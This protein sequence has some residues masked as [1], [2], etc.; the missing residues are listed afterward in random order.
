MPVLISN[1][2]EK[3]PVDHDLEHQLTRVVAQAL[4]DHDIPENAE[5]SVVLV[6]DEYITFLNGQY[7]GIDGP[8]DVLSF[9][10]LEGPAMPGDEDE[11][12]LGDV[13]ISL[14][15]ARRQAVEYDHSFT[16]E[17]A[18]LT[19]HG[20]LHLLGYDHETPPDKQK[21]RTQEETILTRAGLPAPSTGTT[22]SGA[23][24]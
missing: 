14:E 13:V 19:V 1:L 24:C 12:M 15:T 2:Q 22:P 6:D 18:Y 7:R 8:T 20:V 3:V 17:V 4:A 21:M 10:M 9:A 23:G 16:R 5:V 11:P